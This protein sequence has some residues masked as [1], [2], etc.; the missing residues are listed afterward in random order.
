MEKDNLDIFLKLVPIET[1]KNLD[2]SNK[3]LSFIKKKK[4]KS[5]IWFVY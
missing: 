3:Y 1:L 5:F 2:F 4:K